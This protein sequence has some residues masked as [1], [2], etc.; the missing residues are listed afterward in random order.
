MKKDNIRDYATEAF[1]FYASCGKLTAD[2]IMQKIREDIYTESAGEF[3]VSVSGNYSDA[4]AHAMMKAEDAIKEMEF[5]IRDILA[6]E[7][8]LKRLTAY[9]RKAVEIV[10]FTDPEKELGKGE[11]SDRVHQAEFAIPASER[12][13]YGWLARARRVFAEER[14]LRTTKKNFGNVCSSRPQ[15]SGNMIPSNPRDGKD[16]SDSAC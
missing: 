13:I 6:V 10:Y 16:N 14:G 7:K 4:V 9:E 5:E 15:K 12:S 1:R 8:T 3:L 11:I 2:E